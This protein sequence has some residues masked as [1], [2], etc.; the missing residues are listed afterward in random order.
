MSR[1]RST[2]VVV[3]PLGVV[4]AVLSL[5][6]VL[7]CSKVY[8]HRVGALVTEVKSASST[9]GE[10]FPVVAQVEPRLHVH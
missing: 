2:Q 9:S 4:I 8:V 1:M 6:Q 10:G 5:G 7:R 3:D